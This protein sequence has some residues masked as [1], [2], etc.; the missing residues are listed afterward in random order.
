MMEDDDQPL[1]IARPTPLQ[2]KSAPLAAAIGKKKG[3]KMNVPGQPSIRQ[4][5]QKQGDWMN[6]PKVTARTSKAI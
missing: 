1:T 5:E 3:Q 6:N 4:K 2:V